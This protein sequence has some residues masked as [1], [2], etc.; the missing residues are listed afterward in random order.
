MVAYFRIASDNANVNCESQYNQ[1]QQLGEYK[2]LLEKPL[3]DNS[4]LE[5]SGEDCDG[6][7][8]DLFLLGEG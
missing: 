5:P 7:C 1:L 3:P 2:C 4:L 6:F 8:A